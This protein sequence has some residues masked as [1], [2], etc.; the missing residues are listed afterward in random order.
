MKDER[1]VL[2][3]DE[4]YKQVWE[5]PM[6]KLSREYG[7]SDRGLAKICKRLNIPV[8]PRGYWAK[9]QN[10]IK[11][12]KKK[13]PKRQYG[14]SVSWEIQKVQHEEEI[15]EILSDDSFIPE[16]IKNAKKIIPPKRLTSPHPLVR[17]T[18]VA[19]EKC[20]PDKYGAIRVWKKSTIDLRIS[21]KSLNKA[22]R[23]MNALIRAFE[24]YGCPVESEIGWNKNP[25]SYVIIFGEKVEFSIY[26]NS[27]QSPNRPKRKGEYFHE[28]YIY[29]MS[30]RLQIQ[31]DCRFVHGVRNK[32]SDTARKKVE[33]SLNDVLIGAVALAHVARI[34]RE[35][36]EEEERQREEERRRLAEK[37][38]RLEEEMKRRAELETQALS[39]NKSKQLRDFIAEVELKASMKMCSMENQTRMTEWLAWAKE[40]AD[41]IDPLNSNFPFEVNS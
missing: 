15:E 39:W 25:S 23:I 16:R 7:L 12:P 4:L 11:V 29:S 10:G 18:K 33:D 32:W 40:H 35:K 22:L 26:E 37:Q 41:R 17:Q 19:Y 27:N 36:R 13:L 21:P 24:K 6:M 3:R 28:K 5:T 8:P 38:R 34:E 20:K 31:L 1:I 9:V 14:S 2:H 30:G